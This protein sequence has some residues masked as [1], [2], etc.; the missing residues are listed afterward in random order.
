MAGHSGATRIAMLA[1]CGVVAACASV[2]GAQTVTTIRRLPAATSTPAPDPSP[3][4][5]ATATPAPQVRV[6]RRAPVAA[7]SAQTATPPPTAGTRPAPIR[8][9]PAIQPVRPVVTVVPTLIGRTEIT[10]PAALAG[11][12][13]RPG[14]V[15]LRGDTN[16][17]AVKSMVIRRQL[18]LSQLRASPRLVIGRA[19]ADLSPLLTNP[20]SLFNISQNLRRQPALAEVVSEDTRAWEGDRGIVVH[21]FLSYR[22][23]PG[24]CSDVGRR[25]ALARVGIACAQRMGPEALAAAFANPADPRYVADTA[26]RAQKLQLAQQRGAL[27]QA[28][29]ASDLAKLRGMLKDPA[30]AAQIDS[31][32]G[33]GEAARL[34]LLSDEDLEGEVIN[35]GEV[36]VEQNAFLPVMDPTNRAPKPDP[37]PPPPKTIDVETPLSTRLFLTGFTLADNYEWHQRIEKTIKRCLVGCSKTYYAEA[38]V[39][40]GYGFGMRFPVQLSG[41]Y[42]YHESQGDKVAKVRV[43]FVPVNADAQGYRDTGLPEG[44][45][46]NGKE[47]IAQ[48]SAGA[49]FTAD[50]PAIPDIDLSASKTIDFTD[51]LP[52]GDFHNGQLT[53]PAPGTPNPPEFVKF[54]EDIDL[55]GGVA[56]GGVAGAKVFPGIRV[57]LISGGLTFNVQD[58]DSKGSPPVAVNNGQTVDLA[59]GANRTSH[60]T[61]G[62]PSYNLG[63]NITPGIEARLFIDLAVWSHNWDFPVWLPQLSIQVPSGGVN[64][65]CHKET[66]CSRYYAYSPFSHEEEDDA[67]YGKY[68]LALTQWREAFAADNA[69]CA[70]DACRMGLKFVS[71]GYY[72]NALKLYTPKTPKKFEDADV[73]KLLA[74]ANDEAKNVINDGQARQ[75]KS[76][77]KSFATFWTVWWGKQCADKICLDK[78]KGIAKFAEAEAN[79]QQK[80]NPDWSTNQVIGLVGQ[81]FAKVFQFEVDASKQRVTAQQAA[82]AA[83]AAQFPGKRPAVQPLKVRMPGKAN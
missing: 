49:H 31:E 56:N 64:F 78:V 10:P 8:V 68:K 14:S 48:I 81:K 77:A 27:I 4:P 75:T 76:A 67:D 66:V 34:A 54:F 2:L 43:D 79:A 74:G 19:T 22:I 15:I 6:I 41:L 11:R 30:Q 5:T 55:L 80:L 62:D 33:A 23:R 44:K 58:L 39:N 59:I 36:A 7:E 16:S 21:S 24:A 17:N 70:D 52:P 26:S 40:F 18:S 53:P 73:Q 1:G 32:R 83:Q 37:A 25:T 9:Q 42:S 82:E 60:F 12:G 45:I 20:R 50:L 13:V 28:D 38:G 35:S 63:L 3:T 61:I 29:L 72:Y 69:E 51:L 46:F 65:S 47:L 71:L 57:Q